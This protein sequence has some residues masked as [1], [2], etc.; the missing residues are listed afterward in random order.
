MLYRVWL[1]IGWLWVALVF[2]LSLMQHPPEPIHFDGVDKLEHALVYAMLMLWFCQVYVERRMRIKLMLSFVAMGVGIEI[3]QGISG[4]RHF[5]YTDILA[6][7]TG[8]LIGWGLAQTGMGRVLRM[9]E[10]NGKC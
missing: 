9:L 6:N 10:N 1:A 2:Y 3:L 7:S 8:I 5:E 4:Y